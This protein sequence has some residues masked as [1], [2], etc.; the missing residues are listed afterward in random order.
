MTNNLDNHID[1]A[2]IDHVNEISVAAAFSGQA[3]VF[4]VIYGDDPIVNYKRTSVREHIMRYLRTGDE[5]LELNCGTGEDS[6]Y[7]AGKGFKL[8]ATDISEGML[9]VLNQKKELSVATQSIT[10][11]NCS[12]TEL[13]NLKNRGPFDYIFSNFGGL[14]CTGNLDKVLLSFNDILRPGGHVSLVVISRF[15]FWETLLLFKGKFKTAFRRFLSSGGRQ[16]HVEGHIFTCWY[17]SSS[18]IAHSLKADFDLIRVEGLCTIV[19]PSYMEG[20]AQKYPRIFAYL[21]RQENKRKNSFPW[22]YIGDYFIIT[23]KKK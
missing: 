9:F 4:D 12:F 10:F 11:E 13:K 3:P 22:K 17:Y 20:F 5:I 2:E 15:C 6:L 7:F 18:F 23:L 16:A 19:P 8:H 21:C 14:N 1:D